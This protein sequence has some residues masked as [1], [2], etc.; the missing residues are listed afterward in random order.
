MQIFEFPEGSQRFQKEI[1][2]PLKGVRNLPMIWDGKNYYP[3]EPSMKL[4]DCSRLWA[5]HVRIAEGA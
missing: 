2:R 3:V 5:E 4:Y 1:D